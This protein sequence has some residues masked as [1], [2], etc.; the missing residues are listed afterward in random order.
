MDITFTIFL[1][2]LFIIIALSA[3]ALIIL[4]AGTLEYSI[5]GAAWSVLKY[6]ELKR[7]GYINAKNVTLV[8]GAITLLA[9][10][11]IVNPQLTFLIIRLPFTLMLMFILSHPWWTLFFILLGLYRWATHI[12]E[13]PISPR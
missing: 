4:V 1:I 3:R 5:Y 12:D 7:R 11:L 13:G 2:G 8:L 9:Y 10:G 6:K